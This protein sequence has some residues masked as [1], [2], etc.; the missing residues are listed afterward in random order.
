MDYIRQI[1]ADSLRDLADRIDPNPDPNSGVPGCHCSPNNRDFTGPAYRVGVFDVENFGQ[2]RDPELV[3]ALV[4][5]LIAQAPPLDVALVSLPQRVKKAWAH[6]DSHPLRRLAARGVDV[7]WHEQCANA[8]DQMLI[9]AAQEY[10]AA[11]NTRNQ[12]AEY[13]IASADHIFRKLSISGVI[14]LVIHLDGHAASRVLADAAVNVAPLLENVYGALR[15]DRERERRRL[16]RQ[17]ARRRKSERNRLRL[18]AMDAVAIP[19]GMPMCSGA[20][21]TNVLAAAS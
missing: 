5:D 10:A 18:I 8:A 21:H 4:D 16:Y 13:V 15:A 9:D 1:A 19:V 3:I 11:A 17:R 20:V 2:F 7:F 12:P 6:H 14:S